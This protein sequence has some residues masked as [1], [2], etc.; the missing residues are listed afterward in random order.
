[1]PTTEKGPRRENVNRGPKRGGSNNSF[2]VPMLFGGS[3][4]SRCWSGFYD[5]MPAAKAGPPRISLAQP[6]SEISC[7]ISWQMGEKHPYHTCRPGRSL[8]SHE[9]GCFAPRI[10]HVPRGEPGLPREGMGAVWRVEKISVKKI[11]KGCQ[12]PSSVAKQSKTRYPYV[13]KTSVSIVA[14]RRNSAIGR[15]KKR[16]RMDASTPQNAGTPRT[17]ASQEPGGPNQCA[18]KT[19]GSRPVPAVGGRHRN[20]SC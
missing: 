15:E 16:R 8:L 1:M 11:G 20:W 2:F 18:T 10:C 19:I 17:R 5:H 6:S 14:T 3:S 13:R 7:A 12:L 9:A 4:Q